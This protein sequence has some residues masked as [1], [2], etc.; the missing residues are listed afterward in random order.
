[1]VVAC[2][3]EGYSIASIPGLAIP[4]RFSRSKT[5][6]PRPAPRLGSA[7]DLGAWR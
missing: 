4:I 2:P 6:L 3:A 7:G 5:N 1:M